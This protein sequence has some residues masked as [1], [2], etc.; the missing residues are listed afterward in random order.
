MTHKKTAL[1]D[2][3]AMPWAAPIM[4]TDTAVAAWMR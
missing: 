2:R 3:R 4:N 1:A